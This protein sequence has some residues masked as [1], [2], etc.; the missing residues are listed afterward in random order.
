[1]RS[2]SHAQINYLQA[3]SSIL[4]DEVEVPRFGASANR[5]NCGNIERSADASAASR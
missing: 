4:L 3:P 5:M 1:M 2:A